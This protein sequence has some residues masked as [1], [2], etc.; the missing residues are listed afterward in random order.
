MFR[1]VRRIRGEQEAVGDSDQAPL[2][3]DGMTGLCAEADVRSI[4]AA[5]RGRGGLLI[6]VFGWEGCF[7]P[8][9][10]FLKVWRR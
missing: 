7:E 2:R 3:V 1:W 5:L 9:G 6:S 4:S 8:V 10:G